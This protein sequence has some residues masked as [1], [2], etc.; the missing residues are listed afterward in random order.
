V[1]EDRIYLLHVRDAIA[2]ILVYAEEGEDAFLRETMRQDA[3]I[4]KLEVIGEAVKQLSDNTR[5][6]RPDIPWRR[7]AGMRDR[8]IHQYFGVDLDLVWNVVG[9]ELAALAAAVEDLLARLPG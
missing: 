4:R 8:L 5:N 6:A 9:Q 3:I 1:S 2:D 7:V